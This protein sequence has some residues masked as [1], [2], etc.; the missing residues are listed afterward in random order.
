MSCILKEMRILYKSSFSEPP[1]C[2][3]EGQMGSILSLYRFSHYINKN[4]YKKYADHLLNELMGEL[5]SI[6]CPLEFSNGLLE[7]DWGVK[8][9]I[10]HGC[11][12]EN[13]NE[14]SA[15]TDRCVIGEIH[16][17]EMTDISVEHGVTGLGYCILAHIVDKDESIPIISKLRECLICC[18]DWPDILPREIKG[19]CVETLMLI[20]EFYKTSIYKGRTKSILMQA[21]YYDKIRFRDNYI[22]IGKD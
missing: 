10:K 2:F 11:A 7:I 17:P 9:L 5:L 6:G 19:I 13:V 16:M 18:I 15:D 22:Y 4:Y 21:G 14:I 8:Y 12:E 20:Q 1:Y 3:L